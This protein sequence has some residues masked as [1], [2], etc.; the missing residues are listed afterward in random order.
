MIDIITAVEK[1]SLSEGD[2]L[3]LRVD[4]SEELGAVR[5][6]FDEVRKVVP[7]GKNINILILTNDVKLECVNKRLMRSLGWIKANKR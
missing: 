4:K 1:M 6:C 5:K 7:R 2:L 3:I